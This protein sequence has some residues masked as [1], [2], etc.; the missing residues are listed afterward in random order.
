MKQMGVAY[1]NISMCAEK[2]NILVDT[3]AQNGEKTSQRLWTNSR[4]KAPSTQDKIHH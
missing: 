4:N 1:L 3:R 2:S